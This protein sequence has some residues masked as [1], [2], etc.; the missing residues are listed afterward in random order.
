ME[1]K[2]C[3]VCNIKK[4]LSEYH[5]CIKKN[6]TYLRSYCK[7]CGRKQR[8]EWRE[9]LKDGFWTVYLLPDHNYVGITAC[10]YE[11][12]K[13][14]KRQGRNVSNFEII[15]KY[16]TGPKAAIVEAVYHNNGYD[17]FNYKK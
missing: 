3:N 10:V 2:K 17:G 1:A 11:R 7:E 15:G 4:P 6:A 16:D 14:H 12:M 13:Q 8:R 9:S 5:K